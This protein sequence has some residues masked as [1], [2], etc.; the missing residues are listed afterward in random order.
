MNR[1]MF[2]FQCSIPAFENLLPEPHNGVVLKLLFICAQWHALAKLRMHHDLTLALL[3]HTTTLLGAQMR[4]FYRDTCCKV[5]TKELRREAQ[6]RARR[7]VKAVDGTAS[8]SRKPA[9]L[10]IF[11]IK[12]HFLGDYP[13][14][15]R[16]FGTTDSYSTETVSHAWPPSVSDELNCRP[17]RVNSTTER[18]SRGTPEPT[19]KTTRRNF[20]RSRDARPDC[21]RSCRRSTKDPSTSQIARPLD[22]PKLHWTDVMTLG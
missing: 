17:P 14:V 10:N 6:A 3:E 5:Q 12:F 11:T 20:P 4:L 1:N 18:P 13:S 2:L 9:T 16:R 21:H 19:R 8:S 15:I 7:E 22:D